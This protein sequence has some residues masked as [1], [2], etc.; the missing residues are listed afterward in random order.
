MDC[1]KYLRDKLKESLI[2]SSTLTMEAVLSYETA[3]NFLP[4]Y[5]ASQPRIFVLVATAR[6]TSNQIKGDKFTCDLLHSSVNFVESLFNMAV[7]RLSCS[8]SEDRV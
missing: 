2:L 5:T 6:R 4:L 7:I 3:V 1:G 8:V